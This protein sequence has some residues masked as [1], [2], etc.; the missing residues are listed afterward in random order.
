M[1]NWKLLRQEVYKT[2][3]ITLFYDAENDNYYISMLKGE[4]QPPYHWLEMEMFKPI[5]RHVFSI[6]RDKNDD[7]L[8]QVAY[9]R[10]NISFGALL[11]KLYTFWSSNKEHTPLDLDNYLLNLK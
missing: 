3:I 5:R 10:L 7:L 6:W 8:K 11:E 9:K 2:N 4:I 1:N